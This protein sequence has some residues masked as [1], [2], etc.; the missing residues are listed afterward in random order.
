MNFQ[1]QREAE[2]ESADC[3]KS[4]HCVFDFTLLRGKSGTCVLQ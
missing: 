1:A 2:V 4:F 3:H